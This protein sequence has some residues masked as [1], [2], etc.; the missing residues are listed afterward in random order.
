MKVGAGAGSPRSAGLI[1]GTARVAGPRGASRDDQTRE[2]ARKSEIEGERE[3][4][5][6][7]EEKAA[8]LQQ[9]GRQE[10]GHRGE[11]SM[12]SLPGGLTMNSLM[13]MAL[14]V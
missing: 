10:S 12:D 2:T 5:R 13:N 14:L 6:E 4:V 11:N 9:P 1:R 7:R 8:K 3:K